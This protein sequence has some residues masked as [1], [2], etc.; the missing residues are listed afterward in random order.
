MCKSS[1]TRLKTILKPLPH[2]YLIYA[3]SVYHSAVYRFIMFYITQNSLLSFVSNVESC[4]HIICI[5]GF[6]DVAI[7]IEG[8]F[9]EVYD[10]SDYQIRRGG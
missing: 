9:F 3:S 4:R 1:F 10:G 6:H 2:E 8:I 7:F 5:F